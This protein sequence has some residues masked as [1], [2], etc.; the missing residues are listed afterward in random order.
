M[1]VLVGKLIINVRSTDIEFNDQ[2]SERAH[3]CLYRVKNGICNF[4]CN[5]K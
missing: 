3:Q 5:R 2:S 4:K 1:K